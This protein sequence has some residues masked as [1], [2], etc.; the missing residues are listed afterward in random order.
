MQMRNRM[1]MTNALIR[2]LD[3]KWTGLVMTA[4][5]MPLYLCTPDPWPGCIGLLWCAVTFTQGVRNWRTLRVSNRLLR[6]S[7]ARID[8]NEAELDEHL[9]RLHKDHPEWLN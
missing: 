6:E 4:T 8:A 2:A 1:A 3:W 7:L 5:L 9:K